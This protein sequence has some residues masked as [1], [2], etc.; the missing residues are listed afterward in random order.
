[1]SEYGQTYG[2][3][4]KKFI[5]QLS[6]YIPEKYLDA[7]L[8]N[9]GRISEEILARYKSFKAE[10]VVNDLGSNT[11]YRVIE[12]DFLSSEKVQKQ[13]GDTLRRSL[14]RHDPEK[15]AKECIEVAGLV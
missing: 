14:V 3:T 12:K 1:M 10:P 13:K 9:N 15:L 4:A 11:P 6:K 8:I 2:F 5:E 7:V